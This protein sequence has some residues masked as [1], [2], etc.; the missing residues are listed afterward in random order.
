MHK[1]PNYYRQPAEDGLMLYY[2]GLNQAEF[3]Q[4]IPLWQ[5]KIALKLRRSGFTCTQ[6]NCLNL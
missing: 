4:K 3:Q 2:E 5:E 6:L 1:I